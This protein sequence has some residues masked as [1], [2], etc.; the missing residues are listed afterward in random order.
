[1]S[2]EEVSPTNAKDNS[3]VTISKTI[4]SLGLHTSA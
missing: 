1:M 4:Y 3:D 2:F